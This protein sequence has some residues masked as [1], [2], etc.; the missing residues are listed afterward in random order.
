[1]A[2]IIILAVRTLRMP[3]LMDKILRRYFRYRQ[4]QIEKVLYDPIPYQ[5]RLLKEILGN[6]RDC[7]YGQQYSFDSIKDYEQYAS[8]VPI[9]TYEELFPY[10]EKMLAGAPRLLVSEPVRW[11]AKS[12]G[13]TNARS[14]F[15]PVTGTYLN[16]GHLKCTWFTA[17]AIYNEDP[18]CKLFAQKN[19]IMAGSLTPLENGITIGDISAIMMH[20]YPKIGRRFSTPKRDLALTADWDKKI[21][22]MVAN[23]M[24]DKVTLI[25]GVPTWTIVLIKALLAASGKETLT[26]VWPDLK[27]Y[28]HGGVG[29][30]PYAALLRKYMPE[31]K[32]TF[33]EVYN[34]SEGYFAIQDKSD[35]E[36]MSLLCD[37]QVF[38]EFIP[39]DV[40]EQACPQAL[41]LW[42]VEL[43]KLYAIV[44]TTSAG[45]Y[46]YKIGDLVEFTSL[47]PYKIKV[48][49]RVEQ[50]LNVFG[51]E[52]IVAHTDAAIS[53]A[54]LRTG[55]V[56]KDYTVAP[57]F[58]SITGK[59]G[60]E[61][62]VEFE[63][64]PDFLT[65]FASTL[66]NALRAVNSDYD[67]KRYKDIALAPLKVIVLEEGSIEAW[68]R[69]NGK[70]GRQ[71]KVPRL[72]NDRKLLEGLLA[73][74]SSIF[75]SNT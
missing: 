5:Q 22:L 19:L 46:R 10:I 9:V 16:K 74:E 12:S 66:D 32:V 40:L 49:G 37:H 69:S 14:K 47:S 61:W 60:H 38:Y 18:T 59:G 67:A 62:G 57:I 39:L 53:E 54:S 50:Y 30:G 29:F 71:Y 45:L 24:D 42:Q 2:E 15:I 25:G 72:S 35:E 11:F 13:T 34:A 64:R 28:M 65:E 52:L 4:A 55:A 75:K 48:R 51:E 63:K 31:D 58:M 6:N 43:G 41:P 17:S 3:E 36:G 23:C 68:Q 1:M 56:I 27:T 8:A 73:T 26:E 21:E 33:R 20:H 44:I 70:Y 7:R